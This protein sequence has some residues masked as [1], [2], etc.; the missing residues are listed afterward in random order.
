MQS[1]ECCGAIWSPLSK[2]A[3]EDNNIRLLNVA[4]KVNE[5]GRKVLLF[6]TDGFWYQGEIFHDE[7]EGE[8]I[9][10]WHNDHI[11]C[12]FRA[13]S[14]G[15][16]EFIEDGDYYPVI[17]GIPNESKGDWEWGDIYTEKAETIDY[18]YFEGK[19]IVK[20]GEKL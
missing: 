12:R 19:G 5:S 18:L 16:Y 17:R 11:N 14:D 8:D 13:K 1:I 6:N 15:A 20:N 10:Q 9:G 2:D 7:G 4:T 3:I